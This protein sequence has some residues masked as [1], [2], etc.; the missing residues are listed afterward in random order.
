MPETI[1]IS[2]YGSGTYCSKYDLDF[3]EVQGLK[4]Y[5]ATGY[6]SKTGV[7]TLTRVM[8]AKAGMGL[9]IK[10]EP[11]EYSVPVLEET[12]EN[13]LNMLVG[14]LEKTSINSTS[15]DGIYRNYKYT[16]KS[17]ETSP[18][19]YEFADGSTL[20]AGKAYLQIPVAWLPASAN[21][22]ISIRFDEGDATD[23]DEV[24]DAHAETIY[25]DLMG[26]KVN[27]PQKGV[28][29]IVNGKKT[30]FNLNY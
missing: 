25:Y 2:Q 8:T 21:A 10:G 19:F 3:S 28:I 5:A 6:K 20:S 22:R 9:F 26:R 24:E 29:Y 23:I 11:G 4:A 12:D 30:V 27:N 7:V 15:N 18:M 16:I 14:T 1:T 17:G 13:S